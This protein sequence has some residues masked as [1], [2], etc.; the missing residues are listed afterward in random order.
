MVLFATYSLILNR[1]TIKPMRQ[2][3]LEYFTE[4]F[5]SRTLSLFLLKDFLYTLKQNFK[6]ILRFD[7]FM[8]LCGLGEI[9]AKSNLDSDGVT[10]KNK[11]RLITLSLPNTFRFFLK[12]C[13]EIKSGK[14]TKSDFFMPNHDNNN[15][16]LIPLAESIKYTEEILK[17][18]G[19]ALSKIKEIVESLGPLAERDLFNRVLRNKTT[20]DQ[21]GAKNKYISFDALVNYLITLY[22]NKITDRLQGLHSNFRLFCKSRYESR[23]TLENFRYAVNIYFYKVFFFIFCS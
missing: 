12:V 21:E 9:K 11:L 16:N 8:D 22:A 20:N 13:L 7:Y 19:F 5:P 3:L 15:H 4:K 2:F 17:T 14:R 10:E 1:R 18:E 23:M 6:E